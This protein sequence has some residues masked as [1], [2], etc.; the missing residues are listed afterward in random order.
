MF[1]RNHPVSGRKTKLFIDEEDGRDLA[2]V[3][4]L[5]LFPFGDGMGMDVLVGG[6][7]AG[8]NTHAGLGTKGLQKGLEHLLV[9]VRG[10]YEELCLV[11]VP[12]AGL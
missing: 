6:G 10:F 9:P 4:K 3:G 11:L 2:E 5:L 12:G 1:P 8:C 7:D